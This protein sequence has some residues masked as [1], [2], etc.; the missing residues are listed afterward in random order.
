[1]KHHEDM[2]DALAPHRERYDEVAQGMGCF[3]PS[4][5]PDL[6]MTP[7]NRPWWDH[8]LARSMLPVAPAL[9]WFVVVRCSCS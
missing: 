6:R 7:V 1:M 4:H 8:M 2:N 5:L 9:P 3:H